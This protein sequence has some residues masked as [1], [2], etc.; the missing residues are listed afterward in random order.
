MNDITAVE[1]EKAKLQYRSEPSFLN[2]LNARLTAVEKTMQTYQSELRASKIH[3]ES[4]SE[5]ANANLPPADT[6]A[7]AH[8]ARSESERLTL[9]SLSL[10]DK[11]GSTTSDFPNE[12]LYRPEDEN[13]GVATI[14]AFSTTWSLLLPYLPLASVLS[15]EH[16]SYRPHVA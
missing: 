7:G 8:T 11:D 12:K 6:T 10:P 9:S 1:P 3:T 16:I 2:H 4:Q 13:F 5:H 14:I 15:R